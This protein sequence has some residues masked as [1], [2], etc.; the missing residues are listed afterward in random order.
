MLQ[1]PHLS[2][3]AINLATL[4]GQIAHYAAVRARLTGAVPAAALAKP[5]RIV[6]AT[7]LRTIITGPSP[8]DIAAQHAAREDWY[9][10]DLVR[11]AAAVVERLR[12]RRPAL[13]QIMYEVCAKYGVRKI[14]LMSMRR[15]RDLVAPRQ[16]YFYRARMETK[17][18][19]PQIAQFCGDRDHSTAVHG[20][21]KHQQRI[22]AYR[23]GRL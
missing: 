4:E 1:E 21:K 13:S 18:T 12:R 7:P 9:L 17:M 14:D 20:I 5:A 6:V 3:R 8:A 15:T 23:E 22:A 10:A 2:G 16:E 11:Q 19:L